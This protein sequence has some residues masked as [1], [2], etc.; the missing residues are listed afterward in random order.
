MLETIDM[1]NWPRPRSPM[2]PTRTA[3]LAPNAWLDVRL[4]TN[5]T[6]APEAAVDRNRR[7]L[8]R[9]MAELLCVVWMGDVILFLGQGRRGTASA[10]FLVAA[11]NP[12]P[13]WRPDGGGQLRGSGLEIARQILGVDLLLLWLGRLGGLARHNLL[14]CEP[15]AA[16][17][18]QPDQG[19]LGFS[20]TSASFLPFLAIVLVG[21]SHD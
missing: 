9:D 6:A 15:A 19:Q 10:A 16:N 13:C 20:W 12:Q 14:R 21:P 8:T 11:P 18:R 1:C 7:R 5:A 4:P 2:T 17:Q 3:S